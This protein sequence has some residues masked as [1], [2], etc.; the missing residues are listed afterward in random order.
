MPTIKVGGDGEE[1]SR[2]IHKN[3]AAHN[4][5]RHRDCRWRI[6]DGRYN[7][8]GRRNIDKRNQGWQK[9]REEEIGDLYHHWQRLKIPLKTET[10]EGV[11]F[12]SFR[13]ENFG[14]DKSPLRRVIN[15]EI[16]YFS[17]RWPYRLKEEI[18]PIMWR[19][20]FMMCTKKKIVYRDIPRIDFITEI[21][22]K[23]RR[24]E[25]GSGSPRT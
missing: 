4:K 11:Y 17:L 16:N 15:V 12:G 19:H 20:K 22:D 25:S 6:P 3:C 23:H 2:I 14:I 7:A 24:L 13:V 21:E 10:G 5:W 18:E 8:S 9:I 1:M